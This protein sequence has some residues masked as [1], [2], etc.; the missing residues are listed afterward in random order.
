MLAHSFFCQFRVSFF[1]GFDDSD[2]TVVSDFK[3]LLKPGCLGTDPM[4]MGEQIA[5]Q[6][7]Q[8]LASAQFEDEFVE[9]DIGI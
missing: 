4:N 3:P 6:V 9:L 7:S 1:Q 2:M 5:R 8:H